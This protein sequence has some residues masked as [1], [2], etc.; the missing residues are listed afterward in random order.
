MHNTY[1]RHARISAHPI[2][3]TWAGVV[4]WCL[5][6]SGDSR[7]RIPVPVTHPADAAAAAVTTGARSGRTINALTRESARHRIS[8]VRTLSP[9]NALKQTHRARTLVLI[10]RDRRITSVHR[11]SNNKTDSFLYVLFF[12]KNPQLTR[13]R[14]GRAVPKSLYRT[15]TFRRRADTEWTRSKIVP[16]GGYYPG[17]HKPGY[18]DTSIPG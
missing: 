1:R 7:R 6:C 16:L 8:L 13:T 3:C 11:A 10:V 17:T 18:S 5:I 15:I 12:L 4:I 14:A 2:T 9:I